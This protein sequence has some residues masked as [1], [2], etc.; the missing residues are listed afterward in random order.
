MPD[1][2]DDAQEFVHETQQLGTPAD[3]ISDR[4]PAPAPGATVEPRLESQVVT[5]SLVARNGEA[6]LVEAADRGASLMEVIRARGVDEPFAVC[7]GCCSCATCHVYIEDGGTRP[8]SSITDAEEDLLACLSARSAE[9]R[10]SCQIP[11]T[12]ALEGA[13]IRIAPEE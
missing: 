9:S 7:G 8:L 10:L 1:R 12:A 4:S 13:R 11:V 2:L 5:F 3:K 6:S